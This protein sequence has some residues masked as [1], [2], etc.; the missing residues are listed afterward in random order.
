MEMTDYTLLQFCIVCIRRS[1]LSRS[2]RIGD[3]CM[4]AQLCHLLWHAYWAYLQTVTFV[5][6]C[7]QDAVIKISGV[8]EE[9]L[10]A[11]LMQSCDPSGYVD[12]LLGQGLCICNGSAPDLKGRFTLQ[13]HSS[14]MEVNLAKCSTYMLQ[15]LSVPNIAA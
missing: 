13:Q 6:M 1:R 4:Q 8:W 7:V 12:G 11:Q 9:Q 10:N 15:A 2:A 14:Q 3:P 5:Q